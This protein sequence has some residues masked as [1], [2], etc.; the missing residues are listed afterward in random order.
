MKLR[1]D[2]RY[3]ST[4][5]NDKM[6]RW[7][8]IAYAGRRKFVNGSYSSFEI[9]WICKHEYEGVVRFYIQSRFPTNGGF[10][11]IHDTIEEAMKHTEE[12]FQFFIKEMSYKSAYA[13]IKDGNE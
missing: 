1:W 5:E 2:K 8:R 10:K 9:A 11:N 4:M 3:S 13:K 12:Y 7:A 6:G